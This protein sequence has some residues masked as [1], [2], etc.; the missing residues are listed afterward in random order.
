VRDIKRR[1][2]RLEQATKPWEDREAIVFF[3]L[4]FLYGEV[5]A[6]EGHGITVNR[7]PGETEQQ[8]YDRTLIEVKKTPPQPS[9]DGKGIYMLQEIREN[10]ER[11]ADWWRADPMGTGNP[12]LAKQDT[13]EVAPVVPDPV[14]TTDP[15]FAPEPRPEP[16]PMPK[17]VIEIKNTPEVVSG[18]W[19]G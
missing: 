2:E 10:I 15:V 5:I 6:L 19:M 11:P 9:V 14:V 13:R 4:S 18:H 16:K 17:Q 8:L 12:A 3:R 7:L 1:L